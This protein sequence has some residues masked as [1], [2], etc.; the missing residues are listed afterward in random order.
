MSMAKQA[1][2]FGFPRRKRLPVSV[3]GATLAG[4]LIAMSGGIGLAQD[5]NPKAERQQPAPHRAAPPTGRPQEGGASEPRARSDD[6]SRPDADQP[7]RAQPH[8]GCRYREQTLE[9]IV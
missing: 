6:K 5:T 1:M 8:G 7:P 3:F 2:A 4:V 9:L